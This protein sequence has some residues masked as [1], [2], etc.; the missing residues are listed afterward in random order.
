MPKRRQKRARHYLSAPKRI[1]D[2]DFWFEDGAVF[3]CIRSG[4]EEHL[5][6]MGPNMALGGCELVKRALT[7]GDVI[8]MAPPP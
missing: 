4:P 5:Y 6:S 7:R 2:L 8:P 1:T 3:V